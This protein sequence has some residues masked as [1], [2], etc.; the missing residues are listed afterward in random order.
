ME[1]ASGGSTL[2]KAAPLSL[3]L[4][5]ANSKLPLRPRQLQRAISNRDER[6]RRR[7]RRT[8]HSSAL[9]GLFQLSSLRKGGIV[10]PRHLWNH[11]L[12][13]QGIYRSVEY[14]VLSLT[15][16]LPDDPLHQQISIE[17]THQLP[18]DT[19]LKHVTAELK[20]ISRLKPRFERNWP[21][22]VNAAEAKLTPYPLDIASCLI[23]TL[24]F[25]STSLFLAFVVPLYILSFYHIP[26]ASMVPTFLPGDNVLVE[27]V[28]LRKTPPRRNE[29]ILF[30]PPDTLIKMVRD[31][32]TVLKR[33]DLFVKRVAAVGGDHLTVENGWV[34]INGKKKEKAAG[35]KL[36]GDY[37]IPEG[38]IYVL[39]DN[40]DH[41]IDSRYWGLVPIDLV[42]GR[43]LGTIWP[44]N[45]I[46]FS[47]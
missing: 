1:T 3:F 36:R 25:S 9:P 30:R 42:D 5:C 2:H 7:N 41:S 23:A 16:C 18:K 11:S 39:G 24:L 35:A 46:N 22:L 31:R 4:H 44:V 10:V 17:S 33:G 40:E 45:R 34:Y 21:V 47:P 32:G 29:I 43:P 27:K 12:R 15:L 37:I 20:P 28:S 14:R 38:Y 6:R 19:S 26:S 8:I 13:K